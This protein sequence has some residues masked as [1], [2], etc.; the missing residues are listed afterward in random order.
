M[1][2]NGGCS[3]NMCARQVSFNFLS[4]VWGAWPRVLGSAPVPI[5]EIKCRLR[6]SNP[7]TS[8]IPVLN[9]LDV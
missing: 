6:E 4:M 3:T 5:T 2:I 9:G 7:D 8:P 1:V